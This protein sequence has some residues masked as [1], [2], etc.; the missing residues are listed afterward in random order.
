MPPSRCKTIS[1]K[2]HVAETHAS[3]RFLL[4]Q[5]VSYDLDPAGGRKTDAANAT[6]DP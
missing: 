1:V 6:M 2:G 3:S 4:L 5:H